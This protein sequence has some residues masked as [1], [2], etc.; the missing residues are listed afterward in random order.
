MQP[1]ALSSVDLPDPDGPRSATTWPGKTS[2]E[3][4]TSASTRVLPSPKCFDILLALTSGIVVST[5]AISATERRCGVNP[6]GGPNPKATRHKADGEHD[7]SQ[8][9]HVVRL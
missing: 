5:C 4:F 1:M 8:H 6:Q 7:A 9:K 3:T 2:I